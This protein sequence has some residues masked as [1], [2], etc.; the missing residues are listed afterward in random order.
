MAELVIARVTEQGIQARDLSE[1]FSGDNELIIKGQQGNAG[2]TCVATLNGVSLSPSQTKGLNCIHLTED[3]KPTLMSFDFSVVTDTDRFTTWVNSLATGIILLMSHTEN[4]T[5]DKLNTY[6]DQ[7]GSVGWKYYWNPDKGTNRSS[8]VAIIDCPLKKIMTEQFMGH[9]KTT[10]QAQL[11]IV[12]DTFADIGVTG[13]GDMIAWEESE[14]FTKTPGYAVKELIK[15]SNLKDLNIHPGETIELTGELWASEQASVDKVKSSIFL[16]YYT[17]NAWISSHSINSSGIETWTKGTVTSVVPANCN[18]IFIRLYRYPNVPLSTA[19]IGIRDVMVKLR[20][21]DVKKDRTNGTFGQW[22]FITANANAADSSANW[23]A[24]SKGQDL[25]T[26]SYEELDQ[27]WLPQFNQDGWFDIPD[28][29]PGSRY[30]ISQTISYDYP[31]DT[32]GDGNAWMRSGMG[33]VTDG[34]EDRS[35]KVGIRTVKHARGEGHFM[36]YGG[37]YVDFDAR[38]EYGR[39]Y[40]YKI[41]VDGANVK[42]YLDGVEQTPTGTAVA[43]RQITHF[44]VGAE[45]RGNVHM[46]PIRGS[47]HELS[48]VDKTRTTGTND[49]FYN[50]VRPGQLDDNRT[51]PGKSR[52]SGVEYFGDNLTPDNSGALFYCG[53]GSKLVPGGLSDESEAVYVTVLDAGGNELQSG[54]ELNK[55]Y[56][57]DVVQLGTPRADWVSSPSQ[58]H[59]RNPSKGSQ[60]IVETEGKNVNTMKVKI[61]CVTSPKINGTVTN[62]DWVDINKQIARFNGTNQCADIPTWKGP[63]EFQVKFNFERKTPLTSS[64][65]LE[66]R[67]TTDVDTKFGGMYINTTDQVI[68]YGGLVIASINGMPFVAG[69]KVIPGVDYIVCGYIKEGSQISRIG[70]RYNDVE[71]LQGY[72]WDLS[73]DGTGDDRYYKNYNVSRYDAFNNY[74]KDELG[75]TQSLYSKA[76]VR[77]FTLFSTAIKQNEK[78]YKFNAATTPSGAS[79]AID[80]PKGA[81]IR[82]DFDIDTETPSELRCSKHTSGSAPL[83]KSLPAGRNKGSVCYVVTDPDPGIYI[84]S[85]APKLNELVKIHKLNVSRVY[86][87][88]IITNANGSSYKLEEREQPVMKTINRTRWIPDYRVGHMHIQNAWKPDPK[89]WAIRIKFKVGALKDVMNPLI[90]GLKNDTSTINIDQYNSVESVRVFSYD[91]ARKINTGV[92][93]NAGFKVGDIADVYVNVLGNKVTISANGK[94]ITGDWIPDGT[95]SVSFIGAREGAGLRYN[96]DIYLVE[97]IDSST[98]LCNSRR[99]DLSYYSTV[100]PTHTVIE[101]ELGAIKYMRIGEIDATNTIYGWDGTKGEESQ[102]GRMKDSWFIDG[103][104][105]DLFTTI[106]TSGYSAY[107]HF[108]GNKRPFNSVDVELYQIDNNNNEQLFGVYN[109]N[110][111][112]NS[113][114]YGIP[115]NADVK[116]WF[117]DLNTTKKVI[118][119]PKGVGALLAFVDAKS[120]VA[121]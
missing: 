95:E 31:L 56:L 57:C 120:W 66:G 86:T 30:E 45:K 74:I 26:H 59:I 50:F 107:L 41:A 83:I 34:L 2:G 49:R 14:Y 10:M 38:I 64:Y 19:E 65:I 114:G 32:S 5:N 54:V 119:R 42:F 106:N 102:I 113:E 115:E 22:G 6:F 16:Q 39:S 82:V 12:F 109:A 28:W 52:Y 84:R 40:T 20:K 61:E 29:M 51:V 103:H 100:K 48:M 67:T 104:Q 77:D 36:S 101:N 87:D 92:T 73:F 25:I 60:W 33:G 110:Q 91:A 99:Y 8:Y 46:H 88:A 4:V 89:D 108:V 13:Y 93:L 35:I 17:D 70:S 62:V 9:G 63:G 117:S 105:M 7:I 94:S 55:R 121:I 43:F 58:Y 11:C 72:V 44:S 53:A 47:V 96:N 76:Y 97:L 18:R 21:P 75:K 118:F 3:F 68:P 78:S 79:I 37:A 80:V 98:K 23:V 27:E 111:A 69:S 1:T 71:Y 116:T 15:L 24:S 85:I 112:I 81:M 90:S